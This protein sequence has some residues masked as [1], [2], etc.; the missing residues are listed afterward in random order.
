MIPGLP[1]VALV[2]PRNVYPLRGVAAVSV[3][4]DYRS[5]FSKAFS[6]G[7]ARVQGAHLYLHMHPKA[8][9]PIEIDAMGMFGGLFHMSGTASIELGASGQS[10]GVWTMFGGA[11]VAIDASGYLPINMGGT[12]ALSIDA[13][14]A[15]VNRVSLTGTAGM[16]V[17]GVA[18]AALAV[19][20][21]GT[22]GVTVTAD[23]FTLGAAWSAGFSKGF[24]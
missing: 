3:D 18:H 24:A 7:F 10:R 17:S 5:G 23:G 6:S 15:F 16:E 11:N 9:A 1:G 14:G 13:D 12:A 22:A 8:S 20:M 21:S 2:G 19:T 4:T